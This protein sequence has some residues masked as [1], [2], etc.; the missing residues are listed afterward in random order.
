MTAKDYIIQKQKGNPLLKGM[1]TNSAFIDCL[2][3]FSDIKTKH[4]QDTVK[5]LRE[6]IES[7]K[8]LYNAERQLNKKC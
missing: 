4:L 2:E 5:Y 3:E 7:Y 1:E 6:S 8:R